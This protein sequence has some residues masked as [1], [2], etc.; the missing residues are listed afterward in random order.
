MKTILYKA[1]TRGYANHGWLESYHTF[2]FANYYNPRRIHFGALRVIN[3]DR[4]AAGKGFG[5]HPHDNMEIISIPTFGALEHQDSVGNHGIIQTGDVQVMS[6]G[7]GIT[8]SE[9]NANSD[10]EVR[11]FQLWIFPNKQEATPRY[12]QKLFRFEP[13][14]LTLIV[15]PDETEGSLWIHQNAWLSMGTF[16]PNQSF[17]YTLNSPDNGLLV[18]VIEGEVQIGDQSLQKRDAIGITQAHQLSIL[19]KD[20]S[21]QLLLIEVPMK[22]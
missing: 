17:D 7:T 11:F 21:T 13:N 3:D 14:K 20:S 9:F 6:A 8:H 2:S 16:A 4:V 22:V 10:K 19:I 12:Q 15:S 5:T 1:N 18:M